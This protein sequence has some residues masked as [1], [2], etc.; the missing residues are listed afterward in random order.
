M[1]ARYLA[2]TPARNEERLLPFLIQSMQRQTVLPERWIIV[3]DGSSDATPLLI[4]SAAAQC[5]WIEPHHLSRDR[6]R[7]PGERGGSSVVAQYLPHRVWE[8][9]DYL[10][11]LDADISFGPRFIES[12]IAEFARDHELGIASATLLERRGRS[13]HPQHCAAFHTRGA[14]KVYSS[15]CFR[16]IG[17]VDAGPAWDSLDEAR[18]MM[19][20]FRTRSFPHITA[21]HHRPVGGGDGRWR[22]IAAS[23][24]DAYHT[25][26]SPLFIIARAAGRF[27]SAPAGVG[28][29]LL[30]SG[31][32]SALLRGEPRKAE[33]AL[34]KYVRQQ[35]LRRL[36]LRDSRWK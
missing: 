8:T 27:F 1:T 4:D 21:I 11:L 34:A 2:I 31:Y 19:L 18:A 10:V 33:P 22:V 12:L 30:L 24:A 7:Q 36:F 13:L 3:D 32:V 28:S 9:V 15:D 25:G 5:R 35:Q 20:G 14:T 26:T 17:G 29:V 6:L 23:G 16:A